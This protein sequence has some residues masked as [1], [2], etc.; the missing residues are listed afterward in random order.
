[1]SIN[2]EVGRWSRWFCSTQSFRVLA[3]IYVVAPLPPWCCPVFPFQ[4]VG[5]AEMRGHTHH[6]CMVNTLPHIHREGSWATCC[7]QK[8]RGSGTKRKQEEWILGRD[9]SLYTTPV[10]NNNKWSLNSATDL[11]LKKMHEYLCQLI[12]GSDFLL[13]KSIWEKSDL[14]RGKEV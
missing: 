9:S 6:F 3:P 4:P 12:T 11:Q 7:L 5:R 13:H 2:P 14:A 8:L 10:L 1:M